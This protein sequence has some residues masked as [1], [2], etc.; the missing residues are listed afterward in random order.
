[1][2]GPTPLYCMW[3]VPTHIYSPFFTFHLSP[4]PLVAAQSSHRHHCIGWAN[5]LGSQTA[6]S[7][8]LAVGTPPLPRS[9]RWLRYVC[10]TAEAD[11]ARAK[12]GIGPT[13]P[14]KT[15]ERSREVVRR[16]SW[17]QEGQ[18]VWQ[19]GIRT[20]AALGVFFMGMQVNRTFGWCSKS[21][22]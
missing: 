17:W 13:F 18:Q 14:E 19:K 2:D 8:V 15:E 4:G 21:H 6:T 1:M 5:D 9:P 7:T 20:R 11:T 3:C 10:R 22:G 12:P 16:L